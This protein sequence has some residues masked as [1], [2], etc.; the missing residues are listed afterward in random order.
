ME[1]DIKTIIREAIQNS[2]HHP[3]LFV[4]SGMSKRYKGTEKWDELLRLFCTEFSGNEFQYDVYANKI[5]EEDYYGQQPAIA[6]LLEKDYNNEV[7]TA[8]KYYEF[9]ERH[10]D[11][12]KSKVSALK[13][14]ISEHLSD[15]KIPEGNEELKLLANITGTGVS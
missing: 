15:C 7:L 6:Y 8:D 5:D 3:F 4:G 2:G 12:L 13:I 14:A 10:K 1:L 11:E 9:R